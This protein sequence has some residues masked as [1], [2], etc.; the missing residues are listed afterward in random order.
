M[1]IRYDQ[2]NAFINECLEVKMGISTTKKS[3]Y[4]RYILWC[5]ENKNYCCGESYFSRIFYSINQ[6]ITGKNCRDKYTLK[7][8]W[9]NIT[10]K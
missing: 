6:K 3:V 2:I 8:V 5:N 7:R 10:I 9:M 4:E 1:D